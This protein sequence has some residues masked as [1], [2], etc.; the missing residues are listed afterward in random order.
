MKFIKNIILLLLLLFL[1]SQYAIGQGVDSLSAKKIMARVDSIYDILP[2]NDKKKIKFTLNSR[3]ND[4]IDGAIHDWELYNYLLNIFGEEIISFYM[5]DGATEDDQLRWYELYEKDNSQ[6][7]QFPLYGAIKNSGSY[8]LYP[9]IQNLLDNSSRLFFL[10]HNPKHY[11]RKY[12][13]FDVRKMQPVAELHRYPEAFSYLSDSDKELNLKTPYSKY[14]SEEEFLQATQMGENLLNEKRRLFGTKHPCY[15]LALSN[16]SELYIKENYYDFSKAIQL[17][18]EALNIYR[19]VGNTDCLQLA[20]QQLCDIYLARNNNTHSDSSIV[21]KQEILWSKEIL[22][23]IEP[24]L[25]SNAFY[26]E[27]AR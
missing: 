25:G 21:Y 17:Q 14:N 2:D 5:A 27:I 3:R 10:T 16:L 15:A 26:V 12:K 22:S 23:I 13:S 19:K 7:G 20:A 18:T 6:K 8:Y 1:Q 11:L 4:F 24:I 9:Q